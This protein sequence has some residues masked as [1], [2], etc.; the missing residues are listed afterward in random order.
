[1]IMVGI[2]HDYPFDW[3]Q[4]MAYSFDDWN[5]ESAHLVSISVKHGM[6][7]QIETVGRSHQQ[8]RDTLKWDWITSRSM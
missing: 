8:W 5:E 7:V 2:C 6:S 3:K 1:M 4:A